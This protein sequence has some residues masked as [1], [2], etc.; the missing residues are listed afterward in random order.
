MIK[1]LYFSWVRE[2]LGISEEL[3]KTKANNIKELIDELRSKDEKYKLAFADLDIIR[4]AADQKLVDIEYP[5][6]NVSEVAFFPPMT[7]G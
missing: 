7:G 5:L 1:I 3:L 6:K 4:I 2:K